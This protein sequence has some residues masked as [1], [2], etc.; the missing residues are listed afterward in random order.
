MRLYDLLV[1]HV[2]KLAETRKHTD[3]R[4]QHYDALIDE[5]R[6][7]RAQLA[8]TPEQQLAQMRWRIQRAAPQPPLSA[9]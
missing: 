3:P 5:E 9:A 2:E 1:E 7:V 8:R 4:T 6:K